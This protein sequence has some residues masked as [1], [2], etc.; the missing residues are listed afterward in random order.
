MITDALLMFSDKQDMT[1]A[2]ANAATNSTNVI[3]FAQQW[4]G[5]VS[6]LNVFAGWGNLPASS[7]TN[8]TVD[9]KVQ[10]S[11]DAQNWTTLEEFPG[12]AIANATTDNPFLVRA[13]LAVNGSAYRYAQLVYTPSAQLTAGTI[14]AGINLTAPAR[15][16]YPRNYVA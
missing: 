7:G 9:V 2:A 13:R 16:A 12:V 1:A 14:T 10:V 4:D 6:H 15:H 5:G 11:T 3:D 8:V